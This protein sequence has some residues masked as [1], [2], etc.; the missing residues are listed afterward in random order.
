MVFNARILFDIL[1]DRTVIRYVSFLM[2]F[3]IVSACNRYVG[4]VVRNKAS[5]LQKEREPAT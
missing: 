3:R 1:C 5:V 4:E 2:K